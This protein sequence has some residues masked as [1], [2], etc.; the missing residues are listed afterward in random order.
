[1]AIGAKVPLTTMSA[2]IDGE[3]LIIVIPRRLIP[4]VGVMA[5]CAVGRE[6]GSLMVRVGRPVILGLMAS[7]TFGGRIIETRGVAGPAGDSHMGAGQ[8][9]IGNIMIEE[10]GI[11]T[12][13]V[14][15]LGAVVRIVIG[16][17]VR[18]VGIKIV[19]FVA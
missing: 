8:G 13:G 12:R 9:E 15:A 18:V 1:M 14:V 11:P 3:I 6:T 19:I 7:Q 5:G 2:R 16:L 4:T 17:M 10:V